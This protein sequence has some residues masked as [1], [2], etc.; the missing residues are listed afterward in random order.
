[1]NPQNYTAIG[2]GNATI[3][4]EGPKCLPFALDFSAQPSYAIDLQSL[5]SRN[6][7][8]VIQSVFIDNSANPQAVTMAIDGTQQRVTA[9][10]YT[11]GYYTVLIPNP[12]RFTVSS[13]GAVVV[14]LQCLN[15]PVAGAVWS[16]Q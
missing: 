13:A 10:A 2:L 3:P 4:D 12:P 15:V 9:K 14:R 11:Q 1:M 6:F 16:T 5:Q 8:S 7:L